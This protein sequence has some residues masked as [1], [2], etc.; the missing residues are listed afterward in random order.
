MAHQFKTWGALV[1]AF[2]VRAT[3]ALE[4]LR[5]STRTP[6]LDQRATAAHGA[7]VQ[8]C[9][10]MGM[11]SHDEMRELRQE[12]YDWYKHSAQPRA[13]L[14]YLCDHTPTVYNVR[15]VWTPPPETF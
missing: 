1:A 6:T 2:D 12:L 7:F 8:L 14:T 3:E 15:G 13:A 11:T 4:A 5:A 10:G 9:R